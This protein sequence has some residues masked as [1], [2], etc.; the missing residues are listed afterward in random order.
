[1]DPTATLARLLIAILDRDGDEIRNAADDLATWLEKGG[2][3]PRFFPAMG[4]VGL[5]VRP[6]D[7]D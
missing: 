2:A 6:Q 3:L 5:L 1:M 7:L 4:K